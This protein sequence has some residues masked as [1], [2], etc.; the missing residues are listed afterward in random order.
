M[1]YWC[2][3]GVWFKFEQN[4]DNYHVEQIREIAAINSTLHFFSIHSWSR[5]MDHRQLH[6]FESSS[7]QLHSIRNIRRRI[8]NLRKNTFVFNLYNCYES[9]LKGN[10]GFCGSRYYVI[11]ERKSIAG[12]I[13]DPQSIIRNPR[14]HLK[15]HICTQVSRCV[16]FSCCYEPTC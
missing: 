4:Q 13:Y 3:A 9:S 7:S 10:P 14:I 2:I 8:F 6:C 5:Y 15:W 12:D 16:M 1:C 11:H